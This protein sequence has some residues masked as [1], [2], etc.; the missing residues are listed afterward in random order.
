MRIS[1]WSSDVCSSDLRITSLRSIDWE[2]FRPNFFVLASPGALD[3]YPASYITA[4]SV[5]ASKPRFTAGLVQRFPNLSV[6]DIDAGLKQVRSI[7]DQVTSVVKVVFWFAFAAGVLVLLAAIGASQD[8][9][10]Q[11][12]GVM[13]VL[14]GRSE[15]RR[16][17]KEC[18]SRCRSRWS[19]Y[20]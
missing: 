16:V 9:R 11:E 7:R 8:E 18:V 10:L 15:E 13:R 3:G 5:P 14:G 1:D 19:P 20:H 6:I 17:G 2:S 4:V 12:G